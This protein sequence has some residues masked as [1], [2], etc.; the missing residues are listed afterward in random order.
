MGLASDGSASLAF[1]DKTGRMRAKFGL[2]QDASPTMEIEV[3]DGE[4]HHENRLAEQGTPTL[5]L[6]DQRGKARIRLGLTP[7]GPRD[8]LLDHEGTVRAL[9]GLANDESPLSSSSTGRAR[10]RCWTQR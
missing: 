3:E 2:S 6:Y 10:T 1:G 9:V 5:G 4:L 7:V 8:A